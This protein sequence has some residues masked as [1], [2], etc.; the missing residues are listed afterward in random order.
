[1]ESFYILILKEFFTNIFGIH[2]PKD[3]ITV[4]MTALPNKFKIS[5]GCNY[6]TLIS[7]QN[8][9]YVWGYNDAGRLGL[10]DE[11]QDRIRPTKLDLG[12]NGRIKLIACGWDFTMALV[13]VLSK[14]SQIMD[15]LYV[16]G[17]NSNAELGLGDY[18]SRF[19]T[20]R[21]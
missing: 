15:K 9:I 21:T 4:I 19:C 2:Y 3:I 16:W 10:G 14:N 11:I 8:E 5:C 17:Y 20:D 1:M 12:R 13:S 7:D 18:I 6:S